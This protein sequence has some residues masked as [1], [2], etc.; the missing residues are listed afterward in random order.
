MKLRKPSGKMK[1]ALSIINAVAFMLYIVFIIPFENW[2][3][4]E[5]GGAI[6]IITCMILIIMLVLLT[7]YNMTDGFT[8]RSTDNPDDYDF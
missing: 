1:A 6:A 8:V 4:Q 2:L 7:V 5:A 3:A